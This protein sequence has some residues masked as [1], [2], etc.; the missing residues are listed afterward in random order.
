MRYVSLHTEMCQIHL[1]L[2]LLGTP[3]PGGG[4]LAGPIVATSLS[5]LYFITDL[6]TSIL[7]KRAFVYI[8]RPS[9][10]ERIKRCTL[11]VRPSVCL[12]VPCH[13]ATIFSKLESRAIESSN[14]V[15][16]LVLSRLIVWAQCGCSTDVSSPSIW[17]HVFAHI[18]VKS[19]VDQFAST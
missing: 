1:L 2:G 4:A 8:M 12:S 13:G 3:D 16:W 18:F 5:K 15:K 11:S 9:L 6:R 14:S 19:E 10:G 17:P 7:H